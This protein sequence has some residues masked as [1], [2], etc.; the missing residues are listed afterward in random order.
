[1][2]FHFGIYWFGC[3]G[4]D[5]IPQYILKAVLE[6]SVFLPLASPQLGLQMC[7]IISF[8]TLLM[9]QVHDVLKGTTVWQWLSKDGFS[10][11]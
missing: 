5:V 8:I 6:S 3:V 7:T 2:L 9:N 1:M 4:F 10:L 11:F